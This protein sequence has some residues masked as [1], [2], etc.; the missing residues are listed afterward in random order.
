MNQKTLCA[1]AA[2]A[3]S[4]SAAQAADVAVY[5]AI[6]TGLSYVHTQHGNN[7]FT[8]A[9][10]QYAGPRV[11]FRGG[12]TLGDGWRVAFILENGFQSDTGALDSAGKMFNRETLL[13]VET[14]WGTF[15]VGRTGPFT[16]GTGSLSRYWDLEPFETGY[17]DAGIQATQVNIWSRHSNT[18]YYLSPKTAGLEF[19]VQYSFSGNNESETNG[20]ADDNHFANAFARWDGETVHI[21]VGAEVDSIG[22]AYDSA[23]PDKDR[24]SAKLAARWDAAEGTALYAGWNSYF[25]QAKFSDV[26]WDDDGSIAFDDSGRG[27]TAHAGYFGIRQTVGSADL[28]ASA[29]YL[30]GK[31]KG[32]IAGDQNSYKRWVGSVGVH[33]HLSRRTMSYFVASYAKGEGLLGTRTTTSN[34]T[35]VQVGLTHFF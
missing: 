13:S 4:L 6:D 9:S 27:L 28:L 22:H 16:S 24:W 2:A 32:A 33:Y 5:G 34:R 17:T 21:A 35:A 18:V 7:S 31:N 30:Q 11:G 10:G 3:L 12:E 14:S 25:N 8:M 15:G 20:L 19:G 26:T 29:Q 23:S 1:T